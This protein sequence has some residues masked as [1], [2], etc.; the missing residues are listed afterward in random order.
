M[1]TFKMTDPPT[2]SLAPA[3]AKLRPTEAAAVHPPRRLPEHGPA[4]RRAYRAFL[5]L[6]IR[7]QFQQ[8]CGSCQYLSTSSVHLIIIK[9][10]KGPAHL[11]R[12]AGRPVA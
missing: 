9:I 12:S 3:A 8:P 5:R 10:A 6:D 7:G 4:R 1:G 11:V 2:A